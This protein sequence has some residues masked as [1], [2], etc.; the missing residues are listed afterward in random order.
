MTSEL[1]LPEAEWRHALGLKQSRKSSTHIRIGCLNAVP[2]TKGGLHRWLNR[3][4]VLTLLYSEAG[5]LNS[6]DLRLLADRINE[7]T[8]KGD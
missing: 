2:T 6:R 1:L 8:L 5:R 7:A 4:D 3:S